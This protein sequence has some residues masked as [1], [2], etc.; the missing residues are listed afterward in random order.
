MPYPRA[1]ADLSIARGGDGLQAADCQSQLDTVNQQLDAK[2]RYLQHLQ[3]Q[4]QP[5]LHAPGSGGTAST[6]CWLSGARLGTLLTAC[7]TGLGCEGLSQPMPRCLRPSWTWV[8]QPGHAVEGTHSPCRRSPLLGFHVQPEL[9]PPAACPPRGWQ[10]FQHAQP[11]QCWVSQAHALG[12][13]SPVQPGA[14]PAG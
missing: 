7:W 9:G 4:L 11:R 1:A 12:T 5:A 2:S 10:L 3:G 13:R 14:L 6:A 8:V